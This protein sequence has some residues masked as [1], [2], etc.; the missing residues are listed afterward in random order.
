MSGMHEVVATRDAES[1]DRLAAK[2]AEIAKLRGVL[3]A[4][5][6][7]WDEFGPDH[8]FAETMD[9]IARPVVS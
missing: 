2:D 4:V 8:G 7:H 1:R 6:A 5:I 3:K 9:R